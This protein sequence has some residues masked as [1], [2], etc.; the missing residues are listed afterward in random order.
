MGL[1][2]K[3]VRSILSKNMRNWRQLILLL[4]LLLLAGC[5]PRTNTP[6]QTGTTTSTPGSSQSASDVWVPDQSENVGSLKAIKV[7]SPNDVWAAGETGM[8]VSGGSKTEP[9]KGLIVHWDGKTWSLRA[10]IGMD[11][12]ITFSTI[13]MF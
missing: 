3:P 10:R 13:L 9:S 1:A 5:Q 8:D 11:Q 12:A 4:A 6:G 2:H 7:V